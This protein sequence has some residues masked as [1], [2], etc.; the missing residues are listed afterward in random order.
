MSRIVIM[1]LMFPR[2]RPLAGI[3]VLID[4]PNELLIP[5]HTLVSVPLRGL[6]FLSFT[7]FEEFDFQFI[8]RFRPLAGIMVLIP[9]E[10]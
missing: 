3:M 6:W 10:P 1:V 4:M 8:I 5:C 7:G 9:L 2:F